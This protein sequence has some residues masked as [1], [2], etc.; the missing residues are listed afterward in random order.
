MVTSYFIGSTYT[1]SCYDGG[2]YEGDG[3]DAEPT[4]EEPPLTLTQISPRVSAV[5]LGVVQ[6]LTSSLNTRFVREA[7]EAFPFAAFRGG[8]YVEALQKSLEYIS[9]A[10]DVTDLWSNGFPPWEITKKDVQGKRL[11]L[12]K[13]NR[14]QII[15][16]GPV[17]V[18]DVCAGTSLSAHHYSR[19]YAPSAKVAVGVC[20]WLAILKESLDV[21]PG[22]GG[23]YMCHYSNKTYVHDAY[24]EDVT[25]WPTL[26]HPV[27]TLAFCTLWSQ[28]FPEIRLRSRFI[29]PVGH[30]HF[31]PDQF[32]N[33]RMR[34]RLDE[35]NP[36]QVE[37]S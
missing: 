33:L 2:D 17:P 19:A 30:T 3:D 28:N 24:M 12:Y 25:I 34:R 11:K 20:A 22:R 35:A 6:R 32:N 14:V 29:R 10:L 18:M 31:E 27:S 15:S 7:R 21:M 23:W 37:S 13:H 1:M 5:Q 4:E 8:G 26:Y 9:L 36:Q 16:H